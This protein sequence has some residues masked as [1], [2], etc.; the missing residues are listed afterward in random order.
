[1]VKAGRQTAL[2]FLTRSQAKSAL[3]SF[4]KRAHILPFIHRLKAVYFR[5]VG[6]H[7]LVRVPLD[8]LRCQRRPFSELLG[9]SG[10]TIDHFPPCGFYALYHTE[11]EK[12]RH[13]FTRWLHESLMHKRAYQIPIAEGGW[14]NSALVRTV[15]RIHQE[16]GIALTDLARADPS[17]VALAIELHV[18]HYFEVF[19]SIRR[20]GY[21][22]SL[23]PPVYCKAE[24]GIH[25]IQN[26]HHRVSALWALGYQ[27]APV[28]VRRGQPVS[29]QDLRR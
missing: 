7:R 24:E 4:L 16:R 1:V 28:V 17:L 21:D 6:Q 19:D 5:L 27:E 20:E 11:P 25:Y 23:Y 15:K 2:A 22:R 18:S 10:Q 8:G 9:F 14:A 13:A 3:R 12:A 29:G 26:G